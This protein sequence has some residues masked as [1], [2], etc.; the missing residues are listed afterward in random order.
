MP[1]LLVLLALLAAI[2]ACA[3]RQPKPAPAESGIVPLTLEQEW[4]IGGVRPGS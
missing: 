1:R 2:S 4:E 3:A